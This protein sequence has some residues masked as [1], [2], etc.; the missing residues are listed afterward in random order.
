MISDFPLQHS[1]NVIKL[2]ILF[3]WIYHWIEVCGF[4][5]CT[6]SWS[7]RSIKEQCNFNVIDSK[8]K[9]FFVF[10]IH[11]AS[12][13]APMRVISNRVQIF[14]SIP[15]NFQHRHVLSLYFACVAGLSYTSARTHALPTNLNKGHMMKYITIFLLS[16]WIACLRTVHRTVALAHLQKRFSYSNIHKQLCYLCRRREQYQV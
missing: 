15:G 8:S 10:E 3:T 6:Y 16:Q 13:A 5:A 12:E 1:I 2:I 14:V 11:E 7:M 9:I 4:F